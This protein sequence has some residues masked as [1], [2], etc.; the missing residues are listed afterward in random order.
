MQ[1]VTVTI[2]LINSVACQRFGNGLSP[3]FQT[4]SPVA[5]NPWRA[6]YS[7]KLSGAERDSGRNP[8]TATKC[9]LGFPSASLPYNQG[10]SKFNLLPVSH[11][12]EL[13][14]L[15]LFL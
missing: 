7:A 3:H 4:M 1:F 9:I 10:L 2:F 13:K 8:K 15:I 6:P 12:H 5:K 14:D 11:W